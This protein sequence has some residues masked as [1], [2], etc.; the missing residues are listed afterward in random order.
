MRWR[1]VRPVPTEPPL[2]PVSPVARVMYR[3]LILAGLSAR[4]AGNLTAYSA[5]IRPSPSRG[6]TVREINAATF[7]RWLHER[8]SLS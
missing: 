6:W 8:Q 3:R 5:G 4:E 1:V 7:L 2:R